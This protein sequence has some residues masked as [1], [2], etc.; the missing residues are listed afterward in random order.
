MATR[1]EWEALIK[2]RRAKIQAEKATAG[3]L[4]P[5]PTPT[6]KRGLPLGTTQFTPDLPPQFV[7]RID[8]GSSVDRRSPRFSQGNIWG[9]AK[10]TP[11]PVAVPTRA[12]PETVNTAMWEA[13]VSRIT[14]LSRSE[15]LDERADIEAAL[16][17]TEAELAHIRTNKLATPGEL[18]R[19]IHQLEMDKALS[20]E[21][22]LTLQ[23][24]GAKRLATAVELAR[25]TLHMQDRGVPV[26]I[27]REVLPEKTTI[28]PGV[29]IPLGGTKKEPL[30]D[31]EMALMVGTGGT[32]R[33]LSV[34]R[35]AGPGI[36]KAKL[37]KNNWTFRRFRDAI[38]RTKPLV[39]KRQ[40]L[41]GEKP[42]L[43]T[44]SF[45]EIVDETTGDQVAKYAAQLSRVP[46]VAFFTRMVG[47]LGARLTND[48]FKAV[49]ALHKAQAD[50]QEN[51]VPL[52]MTRARLWGLESKLFPVD[53]A[54]GQISQGK[55]KGLRL[56]DVRTYAALYQ[57]KM[58]SVQRNWVREMEAMEVELK[59]K[60]DAAGIDIKTL[61][62]EEGGVY[63]G[64]VL[65]G[66]VD[67]SGKLIDVAWLGGAPKGGKIGAQHVRYYTGKG[68][69]KQA[70]DDGYRYYSETEGFQIRLEGALNK[71]TEKEFKA[72]VLSIAKHRPMQAP[73]AARQAIDTLRRRVD[74]DVRM[75]KKAR[76]DLDRSASY[77]EK[78]EGRTH[79]KVEELASKLG[80][81]SDLR[82][83]RKET[84]FVR[85]KVSELKKY[86]NELTRTYVKA[87][88]RNEAAFAKV[89]LVEARLEQHAKELKEGIPAWE[90]AVASA[91]KVHPYVE[92]GETGLAQF[93]DVIFTGKESVEIAKSIGRELDVMGSVSELLKAPLIT[94]GKANA[95]YRTL[96]FTLDMS[97]GTIQLILSMGYP[98]IWA[99]AMGGFVKTLYD[100]K[101]HDD[102]LRRFSNIA[103]SRTLIIS[104]E[105]TEMT[106]AALRGG[107]FSRMPLPVQKGLDPFMRAFNAGM[108]VAGIELKRTF[109]KLATTP[110]AN[111]EIDAFVNEFRGMVSVRRI[112]LNPHQQLLESGMLI[113]SRYNRAIG[114]LLFDLFRG[115][116]RGDLARKSL[117]RSTVATMALSTLFSQARGESWKETIEHMDPR[118]GKFLT[119]DIG[120]VLMGPGSKVRSVLTLLMQAQKDPERL[121]EFSMSNP[122]LRF[123]RGMLGIPSTPLDILLGRNFVGEPTRGW[124]NTARQLPDWLLSPYIAT[125]IADGGDIRERLTRGTI[126][127]AGFRAYPRGSMGDFARYAEEFYARDGKGAEYLMQDQ[128]GLGRDVYYDEL[129][130]GQLAR[131]RVKDP[132]GKR[133]WDLY[134]EEIARRDR[135]APLF[136][137]IDEA[138]ETRAEK[139]QGD[140]T[141]AKQSQANRTV[142]VGAKYFYEVTDTVRET[143]IALGSKYEDFEKNKDYAEMI[144]KWKTEP[145]DIPSDEVVRQYLNIQYDEALNHEDGRDYAEIKKQHAKL[146][147]SVSPEIWES[148]MGELHFEREEVYGADYMRMEKE[149]DLL[150]D[151]W[152]VADLVVALSP[153]SK[154]DYNEYKQSDPG[155]QAILTEGHAGAELKRVLATIRKVR[156]GEKSFDPTA[157]AQRNKKARVIDAILVKW[158]RY[159][160][161]HQGNKNL[162]GGWSY[163]DIVE[164]LEGEI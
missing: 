81:V 82:A 138:K 72:H 154:D 15:R 123:A 117:I 86:V 20:D 98:K 101:F 125:M 25:K 139:I 61:T 89:K 13:E 60:L 19:R 106:E 118:S 12:T 71:I 103:S 131:L 33:G 152:G 46:G 109:L 111:A 70:H 7:E 110:K 133:L 6:P 53:K 164:W 34:L 58:S 59:A 119:W 149:K 44:R 49:L 1:E 122:G 41:E 68:G 143:G 84:S 114:A 129:T 87:E 35:Q 40:L 93:P 115:G 64:R 116:L 88:G 85:G 48:G 42:N 8:S 38:E 140:L 45:A 23:G 134:E 39:P 9:P 57:K 36:L 97:L 112:G 21:A 158:Y 102:Y 150:E 99:R 163:W 104:R 124:K 145:Q 54:T 50:I 132:E 148:A 27:A 2:E 43:K 83:L 67:K 146:R 92:G 156:L 18:T 75:L 144:Q 26:A 127:F 14:N 126:E 105:G 155:T 16:K 52:F 107:W 130:G 79:Q 94:L 63:A 121:I 29:E 30:A 91:K 80:E 76:A 162:S 51:I 55:L 90:K 113:S 73:E 37:V 28:F 136:K 69:L 141:A 4:P 31:W 159:T 151:Y 22:A 5:T 153:I 96:K 135:V 74:N 161:Q 47:G 160:P 128:G 78:L 65:L 95:L 142:G 157:T 62:F 137:E 66:K 108:D 32:V 77:V 11:G 3:G 10:P 56:N 147:E 100:P 120:G 24:T 17:K